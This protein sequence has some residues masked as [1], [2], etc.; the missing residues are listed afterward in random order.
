MR[1]SLVDLPCACWPPDQI[2]HAAGILLFERVTLEILLVKDSK[3]SWRFPSGRVE[4]EEDIWQ[5]ATRE[6]FEECGIPPEAYTILPLPMTLAATRVPK[7]NRPFR[8]K[9]TTLFPAVSCKRRSE[10]ALVPHE[11]KST[12][13]WFSLREAQTLTRSTSRAAC[14]ELAG[15]II[16]VLVRPSPPCIDS[17]P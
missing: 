1:N 15:A 14:L 12:P 5:T 13:Q 7:E 9:L 6:V 16:S 4:P 3:G 2:E 11:M 10:I 17:R 8:A